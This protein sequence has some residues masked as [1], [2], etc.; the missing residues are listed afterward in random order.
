[1]LVLRRGGSRKD[2]TQKTTEAHN[3][4]RID[5]A[6]GGQ[7]ANVRYEIRFAGKESKPN[8]GPSGEVG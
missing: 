5:R 1:M 6:V 7:M 4:D 8:F 2:G 3:G